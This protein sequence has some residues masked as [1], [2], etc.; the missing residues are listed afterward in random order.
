VKL[1]SSAG[2][3]IFLCFTFHAQSPAGHSTP[4]SGGASAEQSAAAAD[5]RM[6]PEERA[7]V[8]KLLIDSRKEYLDGIQD[9]TEAQWNFRPAPLRWTIAQVAEHIVLAEDAMFTG[10]VIKAVEAPPNPDWE[11]KTKGKAEFIAEVLPNRTRRAQAPWEIQPTGKLSKAEV[12]RRYNEVRD[13]TLKFAEQTEV[14]LKEHTLDHPFPAFGTLNAYEWLIYIP[15]HNLRHD[16][17]IAEVKASPG[18]P[19]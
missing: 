8:V 14:P 17:Q 13:R 15:Q 2:L 6:T 18:Y 12:I 19:K 9:L 1:S 5:P 3:L 4:A 7:A 11:S 16:K 10:R